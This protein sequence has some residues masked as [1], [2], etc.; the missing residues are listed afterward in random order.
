[1]TM[2]GAVSRRSFTAGLAAAGLA[3]GAAAPARAQRAKYRLRYGTAFPADHPGA[4]RIREAAEAIA[5]ATNGEVDLQ[6]Y[7]NSQLGG[8]ADMF[9]QVRSGALDFMS[10][11]GVNQTIVP[12]GGIN[13][14]AFAFDDYAKVWAAMDGALGAHVRAQFAKVG[15]HVFDRMLDNGFR[16]ITTAT[17]AVTGPDDLKGLKIRVPGHQLWVTMFGA[18]GAAPTPINF[19]ELYAA[20]Q[21]RIVDGQEN[22]LALISSAKLYEVQKHVA[23]TGHIWDGHHIFTNAKRWA[24]MPE[25]IRAAVTQALS[26]A[27][28]KEREDILRLNEEL[29]ATI[30]KAGVAFGRPDKQPFREVLRKAGFYADWKGKFGPEPWALLET[31]AGPL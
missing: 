18:L 1:M 7:P 24:A 30:T 20:L 6:V 27:A 26:D 2:R 9:S 14:V 3:G 5:K 25:P 23:L 10:T 15:L 29:V 17:K 28:L 8:E 21:T 19:G 31:Y 13:A 22:P 16:N 11:S 12:V 4:V